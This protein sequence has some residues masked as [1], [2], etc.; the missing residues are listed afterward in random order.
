MVPD[1]RDRVGERVMVAAHAAPDKAR[2][3]VKLAGGRIAVRE[4]ARAGDAADRALEK[5]PAAERF[6]TFAGC[7]Q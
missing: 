3:G 1:R 2:A 7:M 4:K 6:D 5:A